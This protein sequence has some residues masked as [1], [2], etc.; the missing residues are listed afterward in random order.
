M[1]SLVTQNHYAIAGFFAILQVQYLKSEKLVI[2]NLTANA[3]F[4]AI[5]R[6]PIVGFYCAVESSLILSYEIIQ[7]RLKALV[8]KLMSIMQTYRKKKNSLNTMLGSLKI[9]FS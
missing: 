1:E 8:Q 6:F 4:S 9:T 3:G 7:I 2:R 5:F